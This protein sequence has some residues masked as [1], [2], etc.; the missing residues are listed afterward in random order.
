[1][2]GGRGV[3]GSRRS[4]SDCGTIWGR[5]ASGGIMGVGGGDRH[6]RI[7]DVRVWSQTTTGQRW[8][9]L[10]GVNRFN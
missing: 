3:E 2:D 5:G 8:R 6:Q 4:G 9:L 7:D 10:I 1:M